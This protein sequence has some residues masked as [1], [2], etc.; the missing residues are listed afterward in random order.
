MCSTFAV[1]PSKTG[2]G[3]FASRAF[4]KGDWIIQEEPLVRWKP[5]MRSARK[6][7]SDRA[8]NLDGLSYTLAALAPA[9]QAAYFNLS[10]LSEE[11][12]GSISEPGEEAELA[13]MSIWMSNAF[14][15]GISKHS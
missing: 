8:I 1:R 10:S 15:I 13:A 11:A 4:N 5:L 7:Q 14:L 3:G 9:A 2:L 6:A 12:V